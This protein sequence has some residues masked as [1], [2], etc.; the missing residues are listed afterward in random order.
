[1]SDMQQHALNYYRQQQLPPGWAD[2]FGVIV[3]GMMDNA[4][5]QDGLAFL[6]HMGEQLAE[7]YP[8]PEA[9]TVVDLEREMNQVLSQ[10]HWGCVDLR[11]Y[12]NRLEIYHLALPVLAN[13]QSSSSRWRMAMAAVLQGLY[14]RWLRGQGGAENV[15][16]S[17]E[18]TENGSILLFRYY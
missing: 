12:E 4:G 11:P 15:P 1:M 13:T 17:C 10:F 8:L 14:S 2:L 7:R 9:L 6:R 5:E 18:E 16:L 3:N